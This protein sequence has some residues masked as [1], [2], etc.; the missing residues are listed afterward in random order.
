MRVIKELWDAV[1]SVLDVR[2]TIPQITLSIRACV[3]AYLIWYT[4][5]HKGSAIMAFLWGGLD[6]FYRWLF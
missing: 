1:G 3:V 6:G 2:L 4:W 5:I